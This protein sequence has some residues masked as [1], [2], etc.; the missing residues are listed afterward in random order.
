[1]SGHTSVLGAA[2]GAGPMR[3]G[4]E[5]DL[6]P[7]L[8]ALGD[9]DCRGLLRTLDDA[10]IPF[11]AVV[12]NHEAKRDR[13]WL[14]LFERLGVATRL[15]AEPVTVGDVALYGLDFVPRSKRDDLAYD[16]EPTDHEQTALVTHGLFE[17]FEHGDWDA[18]ELLAESTVSFD[19]L[20]LGDDHTPQQRRVEEPHEAWLTY[21]GSTERASAS[22]REDRGYNLVRFGDGIDIRR[23]GLE[24]REFVYVDVELAAGE[25]TERVRDRLEQ[26]D[27]EDAVVVVTIEGDGDPVAPADV[28]EVALDRGALVTRVTDH[29]EFAE[30]TEREV[31]FADPDDAVRERVRELG[32]SDAARDIDET[33]RAS[34]VADSNVD[35]AVQQ[36]VAELVDAGDA[37]TFAS[38]DPEEVDAEGGAGSGE[39]EAEDSADPEEVDDSGDPGAVEASGGGDDGGTADSEVADSE[40]AADTADVTDSST[41]DAEATASTDGTDG[42]ASL[43]DYL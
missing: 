30:E 14:D 21:C 18:R 11:L 43:E 27:V 36:R 22:E 39:A 31:S 3:T 38:V 42:D 1:M 13:Q 16:F 12:G 29:R 40:T 9:P 7:V 23:R 32:L 35:E 17:P 25:G 37:Q 33:V 19:C 20:L 26:Y 10:D 5:V 8:D 4:V 28:E 41:D 34:D 24:T 6:Q 15:G 2:A